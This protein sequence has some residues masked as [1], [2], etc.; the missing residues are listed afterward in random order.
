MT[1]HHLGGGTHGSP[2]SVSPQRSEDRRLIVPPRNHGSPFAAPSF[3]ASGLARALQ[4]RE[5]ALSLH[6]HYA[7]GGAGGRVRRL[8]HS[9]ASVARNQARFAGSQAKVGGEE[10]DVAAE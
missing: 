3:A 10:T 7:A 8:G 5:R 9:L 6:E 2:I 4:V 1:G